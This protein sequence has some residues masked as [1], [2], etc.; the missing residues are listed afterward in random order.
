MIFGQTPKPGFPVSINDVRIN[1]LQ[2]IGSHNSYRI[3]TPESILKII[4]LFD[5]TNAV[6]MDYTHLSFP[7]DVAVRLNP[8]N[9][10]KS[11]NDM[12]IE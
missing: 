11:F 1:Q 7:N 10:P 3:K 4:A 8:I 5:S 2:V 9:G 6:Q 12:I